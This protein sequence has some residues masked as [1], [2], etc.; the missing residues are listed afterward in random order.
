MFSGEVSV[1]E[2]LY[3]CI[4]QVVSVTFSHHQEQERDVEEEEEEEEPRPVSPPLHYHPFLESG[5][6]YESPETDS[7]SYQ[8]GKLD[9]IFL[10]FI[11]R[12]PSHCL[13]LREH[14]RKYQIVKL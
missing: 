13:Q 11:I 5:L 14:L 3:H 6:D 12:Q 10:I 7:F 9:W 8:P 2:I 1:A 4:R